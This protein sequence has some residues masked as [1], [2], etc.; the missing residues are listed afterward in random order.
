MTNH[1]AMST[2]LTCRKCG[3]AI[4]SGMDF[5]P[6]CSPEGPRRVEP[7]PA[8]LAVVLL[9]SSFLLAGSSVF[10]VVSFPSAPRAIVEQPAGDLKKAAYE[11]ARRFVS[12]RNP[13]VQSFSDLAQSPVEQ[14]GNLF[15]VSIAT[16]ESR[17][18]STP[19]RTFLRVQVE[20]R[21]NVWVLKDLRQ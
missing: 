9:G 7:A 1:V 21:N 13:S 8:L 2:G 14:L 12:E 19:V 10:N 11:A 5:C 15:T 17:A 20:Y 6:E 18:G 3:T 4:P 16:D